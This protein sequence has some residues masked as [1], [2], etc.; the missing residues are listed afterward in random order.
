MQ[1]LMQK[2]P[3]ALS[4]P[5]GPML[6]LPNSPATPLS[7]GPASPLATFATP[8]CMPPPTSAP[9]VKRQ[10]AER[11]RDRPEYSGRVPRRL[12]FSDGPANEFEGLRNARWAVRSCSVHGR[13]VFLA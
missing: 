12:Q 5:A 10:R 9:N 6:V 8:R 11:A 1:A 13:R 4:V 2:R 7:G 3:Q